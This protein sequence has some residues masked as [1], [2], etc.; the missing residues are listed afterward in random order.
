MQYRLNLQRAA[1]QRSADGCFEARFPLGVW[2]PVKDADVPSEVRTSVP[3]LVIDA[4]ARG[5]KPRLDRAS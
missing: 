2:F 1:N 4:L 5:K 3:P